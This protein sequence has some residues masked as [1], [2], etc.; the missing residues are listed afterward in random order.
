MLLVLKKLKNKIILVNI[1][2]K[3]K[4]LFCVHAIEN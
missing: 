3:I 2:K 4:I 1:L